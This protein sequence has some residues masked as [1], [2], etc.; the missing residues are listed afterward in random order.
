MHVLIPFA[1]SD[2]PASRTAAQGLQLPQLSQ[3]IRVFSLQQLSLAGGPAMAHEHALAQAMG[4]QPG[5][6]YPWA[7]L[8]AAAHGHTD[9]QAWAF[10][11]PCFW[12]VGQGQVVMANPHDLQMQLDESLALLG[13]MRDFFKED[14]IELMPDPTQPHSRWLASGEVFRL[15]T[16]APEQRAIGRNLSP[17]LP[18]HPLIQR[19]QNEMQMLLYTHPVNDAR[20]ARGADPVNSL[21]FSG[22]GVRPVGSLPPAAS[23]HMPA[24]LQNA[25]LSSQW[26]SWQQA[27]SELDATLLNELLNAAHLGPV[28]L[29]LCSED[30]AVTLTN[31]PHSLWQKMGRLLRPPTL[32]DLWMHL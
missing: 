17:W 14:G 25:A 11:T 16:T 1:L 8:H 4:L 12:Q 26:P 27:W 19:L 6:N 9:N 31:T 5:N 23:L 20:T 13:A 3:I 22:A 18:Q 32:Q 21:W 10:V 30:K 28:R 2:D 7:A 29:T 15:L 24:T